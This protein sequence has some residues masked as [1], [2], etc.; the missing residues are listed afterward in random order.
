MGIPSMGIYATEL[1]NQFGVEAIIRIGSAGGLGEDVHVRD[2]VIAMAASSN[3]SFGDAFGLPGH[4]TAA[5]DYGMLS[6][7]VEAAKC[8]QVPV[9]VGPV[10]TSD[11]FYY[12]GSGHQ[13]QGPGPGASGPGDG[14]RRPL[15]GWPRAATR[16]PW[17]C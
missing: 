4:L 15:L 11:H 1:Y 7:A 12:P 2:V 10:Y 9:K 17:P 3:S 6:D 8:L 13:H 16:R 5:A 14:G